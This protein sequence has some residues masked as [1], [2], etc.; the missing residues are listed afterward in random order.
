MT[1]WALLAPSVGGLLLVA[2]MVAWALW[3]RLRR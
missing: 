1:T 3:Q 2:G